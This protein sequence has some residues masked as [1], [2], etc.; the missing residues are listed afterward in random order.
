MLSICKMNSEP[1]LKRCEKQLTHSSTVEKVRPKKKNDPEPM[2]ILLENSQ[3][4]E[5]DEVLK[6]LAVQRKLTE[7]MIDVNK[8]V[9]NLRKKYSD[10]EI[11]K[12]DSE[13]IASKAWGIMKKT[14][15]LYKCLV[16]PSGKMIKSSFKAKPAISLPDIAVRETGEKNGKEWESWRL[17][18]GND[19][20]RGA[21]KWLN[22][23]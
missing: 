20:V 11:E 19:F 13:S 18:K 1:K 2:N 9:N 6:I 15:M 3:D 5:I 8:R 10:S 16:D 22:N 14:G 7:Q 12:I 4:S 17:K 23:M 21:F